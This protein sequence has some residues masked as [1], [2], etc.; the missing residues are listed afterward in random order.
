MGRC[1]IMHVVRHL[2]RLGLSV[3]MDNGPAR[4]GTGPCQHGP[5]ANGPAW[6]AVPHRATGLAFGPG[7]TLWADFRAGPVREAQPESQPGPAREAR[8]ESHAVPARGL[9]PFA[10]TISQTDNN[11]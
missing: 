3:K 5:I 11:S 2:D 1:R 10:F 7:T 6:H 8:L 9:L 4:H